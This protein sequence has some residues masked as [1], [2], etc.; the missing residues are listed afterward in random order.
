MAAG[1]IDHALF[2]A[3]RCT[4]GRGVFPSD[5]GPKPSCDNASSAPP[6]GAHF[7]LAM[8]DSQIR[9]LHVPAWKKTILR[10]MAH[11]GMFVGDITGSPWAIQF[12]SGST[13]TS[14]GYRDK[15]VEFARRAHVPFEGGDY[16]FDVNAGVEW[17]RYLRVLAPHM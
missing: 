7:Q 13:Y 10:A 3:V 15:M 6:M 9:S 11:Y 2:M 4:N 16:V 12:E 5:T 8:S 14:F 17:G 1:R